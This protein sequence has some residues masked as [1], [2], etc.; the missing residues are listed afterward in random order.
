MTWHVFSTH[1]NTEYATA[2][3]IRD[4]GLTV[5]VPTEIVERERG[6]KKTH[7]H[8]PA[9]RGYV[10]VECDPARDDLSKISALEGFCSWIWATLPDGTRKP[11]T[12]ADDALAG[13]FL[14]ELFGEF[15]QRPRKGQPWRP[16]V[17]EKA[18]GT[19]WGKE[20]IG[21]ILVTGIYNTTIERGGRK[22][23]FRTEELEA[24]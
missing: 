3:A 11:A 9:L 4:L 5:Y 19:K 24:A 6:S 21:H 15:D 20:Y 8:R 17:G 10:F 2:Q 23:T 16:K 18:K 1:P 7:I 13:V 12:M 22:L 14:A